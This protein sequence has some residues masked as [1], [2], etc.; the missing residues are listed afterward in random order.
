MVR[1]ETVEE[2]AGEVEVSQKAGNALGSNHPIGN[3]GKAELENGREAELVQ[4]GGEE[5]KGVQLSGRRGER[6]E[7]EERGEMRGGR[8]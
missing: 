8:H 6:I 7:T 5:R 2:A 3:R 1:A 4:V